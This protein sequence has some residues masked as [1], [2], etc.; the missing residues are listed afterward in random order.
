MKGFLTPAEASLVPPD[1]RPSNISGQFQ[2]RFKG[3]HTAGTLY[4]RL[5]AR[6][7]GGAPRFAPALHA[8][9]SGGTAL[10]GSL[11]H[12]TEQLSQRWLS[13]CGIP[14]LSIAA[15]AHNGGNLLQQQRGLPAPPTPGVLP[16]GRGFFVSAYR[17]TIV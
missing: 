11:T 4:R 2:T 10:T 14:S 1:G 16:L 12:G 3:V 8:R 13:D 7:D 6:R 17:A 15:V 9:E 5:E